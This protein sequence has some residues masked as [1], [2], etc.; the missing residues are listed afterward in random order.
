MAEPKNY[1]CEICKRANKVTPNFELVKGAGLYITTCYYC[2]TKYKIGNESLYLIPDTTSRSYQEK[3]AEVVKEDKKI[4]ST[5]NKST[6][7]EAVLPIIIYGGIGLAVIFYAIDFF[8]GGN[9]S[10]KEQT[11]ENIETAPNESPNI[12]TNDVNYNSSITTPKLKDCDFALAKSKA[13]SK[14]ESLDLTF[15][16]DKFDPNLDFD[17]CK[18]TYYLYVK[19]NKYNLNGEKYVDDKLHQL[20]I[21]YT[22]VGE[23]FEF[24]EANLYNP[25]NNTVERF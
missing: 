16:G 13:I 20:N 1:T 17:F 10:K 7:S 11:I 18:V 3:K 21:T 24:N 4:S 25:S 12:S 23:S 9:S 15:V 6:F 22:K 5:S 2:E 8:S 19:K 14:L